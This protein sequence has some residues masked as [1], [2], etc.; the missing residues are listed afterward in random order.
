M[1]VAGDVAERQEVEAEVPLGA[2]GRRGPAVDRVHDGALREPHALRPA[3]GA[4]REEQQEGILR[5]D[6]LGERLDLR[7]AERGRPRREGLG[8][9]D[10]GHARGQRRGER[11]GRDHRGEAAPG[12]RR[13]R[14][15]ELLPLRRARDEDH[16]RPDPLGDGARRIG[17]EAREERRRLGPQELRAERDHLPLGG[18]LGEEEHAVPG[19][20]P[21]RAQDRRRARDAAAEGEEG[22]V[23]RRARGRGRLDEAEEGAVGRASGARDEQGGQGPRLEA[24][25]G[26]ASRHL[27][28]SL[29]PNLSPGRHRVKG[30]AG[31]C[32]V[33]GHSSSTAAST[34]CV[35]GN[36]ST[37]W[38]AATR[39]PASTQPRTS[40]ARVA[41]SQ[42][43]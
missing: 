43:T 30:A 29:R 10:G 26:K 21:C 6:R 37:G 15:G 28:C 24:L 3:G 42:E 32:R 13:P 11:P 16:L 7:V 4:A 9:G 34:W 5:A 25:H 27:S 1:V 39:K 14:R 38:T 12:E 35:C 36:M 40:R 17:G 41:G 20:D 2:R 18:V 33:G 19:R 31:G 8:A 22:E 23:A